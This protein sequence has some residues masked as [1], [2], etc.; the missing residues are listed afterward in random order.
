MTAN[1][2]KI[3]E[4]INEW[5][6]IEIEPLLDDEYSL[7]IR[8]IMEFINV[9]RSDLTLLALRDKIN[10]IFSKTFEGF[11]TQSEQTLDIAKKIMHVCL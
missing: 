1:F 4:I 11:Y 8:Y 7:E 6:P 9:Q 5:N 10:E 3:Q 2:Y